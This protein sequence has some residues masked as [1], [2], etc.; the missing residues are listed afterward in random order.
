MQYSEDFF[1]GGTRCSYKA[2]MCF[3]LGAQPNGP[4][5]RT[6]RGKAYTA[7]DDANPFGFAHPSSQSHEPSI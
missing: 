2:S 3:F 5:T 6:R 7:I 1:C 4:R